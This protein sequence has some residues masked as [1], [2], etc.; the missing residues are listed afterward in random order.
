MNGEILS[1][2]DHIERD[3][4]IRK[5][6]L[7]EALESALLSAS[8]KAFSKLEDVSVK[9][10]RTTGD[11][12]VFSGERE[13][14]H[15][16]FG[17]IAAQTAKQVIIQ[18]IREAERDVIYNDYKNKVGE[19]VNGSIHR[20]ERGAIIV[21][22]GKAEAI[23]PRSEQ[24]PR[25]EYRQ[26]GR[27][28]AVIQEVNKT[29]RGPQLILSRRSPELVRKLFEMEVPE[30]Y[31]GIVRIKAIAREPGACCKVA[32]ASS[33]EK[34][35]SV[36][37][38]VGM[39]GSRVKNIV[40]ELFGEKVD[41][42]RFS[43]DPVEFVQAA[44]SPA[45]V[46]KVT[47]NKEENKL[48]V[49]V[50]DD[51]LSLAIGK[52][53]QNVRLASKLSG[54]HIDIKGKGALGQERPAEERFEALLKKEEKGRDIAELPGVGPKTAASLRAAGFDS[55]TSIASASIEQLTDVKGIGKAT[56]D[57]L[58]GAAKRYLARESE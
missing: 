25:E 7:I 39:R 17:R 49:L 29:A 44:L 26:G 57:K 21:D 52:H 48:E 4:G 56:A 20:F 23:L 15:E 50:D 13:V 54:Y 40:R 9:I 3:K 58:I 2:L 51:Q 37:A 38:C 16:G 53:G 55:V 43:E 22:L 5:E 41:V 10:D 47:L 18:K 12:K 34:V 24:S 46:A 19:I 28:R 45:K 36:G 1:V 6:V 8:R 27:I 30:I 32:V 42:V 14:T 31:E 33:D 11:I 35:D